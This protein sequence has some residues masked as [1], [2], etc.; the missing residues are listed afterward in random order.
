MPEGLSLL[1]RVR[2]ATVGVTREFWARAVAEAVQVGA[3]PFDA[4]ASLR[5]L[6]EPTPCGAPPQRRW[7]LPPR[8]RLDRWGERPEVPCGRWVDQVSL[9]PVLDWTIGDG[10]VR[11]LQLVVSLVGGPGRS[12]V[13]L[14]SSIAKQL[15]RTA[16]TVQ[17]YWNALVDGGWLE[18]TFDRKTGLVTIT[19]TDLVKPPPLPEKPKAWPRLPAPKAG[20]KRRP[21][22]GAK[23]GSHI[24]PKAYESPL[25]AESVMAAEAHFAGHTV[26][27]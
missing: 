25:L 22:G 8:T 1:D 7:R 12:I 20:W 5:E 27:S 19:V 10:A 17:N 3:L 2:A 16:R 26:P 11:C 21:K 23:F 14:T 4:F 9:D 24:K 15:G 13:T 18:R 6:Q